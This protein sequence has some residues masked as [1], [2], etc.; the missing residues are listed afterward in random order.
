MAASPRVAPRSLSFACLI[1]AL[2]TLSRAHSLWSFPHPQWSQLAAI[3]IRGRTGVT[4]VNAECPTR[5]V[6]G[7]MGLRT[8]TRVALGAAR[9]GVLCDQTT[10]LDLGLDVVGVHHGDEVDRDLFRAGLLALAVVGA[11]PEVL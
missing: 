10:I 4:R 5:S 11:R 7:T 6:L 8:H 2:L 9:S 1:P 3:R